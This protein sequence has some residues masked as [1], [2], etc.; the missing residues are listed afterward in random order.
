MFVLPIL[1]CAL[2]HRVLKEVRLS[3]LQGKGEMGDYRF[4]A[5]PLFRNLSLVDGSF[6]FVCFS[7]PQQHKKDITPV[8]EYEPANLDSIE[9]SLPTTPSSPS[10]ELI[11][12][13]PK[14]YDNDSLGAE[15]DIDTL[16]PT[17]RISA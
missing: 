8:L 16:A 3:L 10:S 5:H 14:Q 11:C 12:L 9:K 17:A 4:G 13:C 7:R 1:D 15:A 6:L 2:S